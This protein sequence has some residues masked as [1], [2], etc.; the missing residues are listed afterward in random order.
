MLNDNNKIA[1]T[2]KADDQIAYTIGA[3]EVF[4]ANSNSFEN[5]VAVI[6]G[7]DD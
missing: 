2:I 6:I 1:N 3:E 7:T 5:K 4:H